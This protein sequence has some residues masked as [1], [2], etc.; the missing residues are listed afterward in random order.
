MNQTKSFATLCLTFLLILPY[1]SG[2]AQGCSDAG[3]CTMG[4]M[5][6]DQ[7]YSK[8]VQFKLRSLELNQYRGTSTTSADIYATTLDL[9]VG[10]SDKTSVQF[11]L[12]YMFVTGNL[13]ETNGLGDISISFTRNIYSTDRYDINATIG[14]KI[15]TNDSDKTVT[16][17]SVGTPVDIIAPMYYQTS[18][19]SYDIVFGASLITKRWLFAVGYQQALTE[20]NSNFRWSDWPEPEIYPDFE[21]IQLHDQSVDLLRGT[22]IMF[23]VEH[24]WRFSN[25]NFNLGVL[26]IIR[27]T[28]DEITSPATGE[29]VKLDDTTGPAISVLGGAGYNLN[30][31]SSLKLIIGVKIIDR[32]VN[33]DGLTRDDVASL[34]YVYRF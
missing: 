2:V 5:R 15:P 16:R 30:V 11:K 21:Y 17:D 6:P 1:K 12:P 25:F 14:A 31:N 4:A 26:P 24:N 34:S 20:N 8:R 29:R 33:P 22:D 13:G 10:L 32:D 7:N 27:I 3:F 23:R 19:G 9:N 18:L 28:K